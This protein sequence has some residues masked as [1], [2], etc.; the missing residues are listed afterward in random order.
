MEIF[1]VSK[2]RVAIRPIKDDGKVSRGGIVL[3]ENRQRASVKRGEI[4]SCGGEFT[5]HDRVL[6]E[7]FGAIE[8]ELNGETLVVVKEEDVLGTIREG[9]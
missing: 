3:V 9:K 5:W 8:I 2:G 6:Y 1:D 7:S 4:V